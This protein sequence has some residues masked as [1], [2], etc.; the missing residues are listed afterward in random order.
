MEPTETEKEVFVLAYSKYRAAC[1]E[2][3]KA[4]TGYVQK[5]LEAQTYLAT[6]TPASEGSWDPS[7]AR[8]TATVIDRWSEAHIVLGCALQTQAA[9]LRNTANIADDLIQGGEEATR[10]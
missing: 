5:S 8:K 4:K 10:G 6:V 7:Q 1:E 2:V 9:E 3:A